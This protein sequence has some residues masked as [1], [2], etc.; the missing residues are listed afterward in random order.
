MS[1]RR[2]AAAPPRIPGFEHVAL[3]GSGGFSDVFLYEQQRPRRR[4]AVKVLL[5]EWAD[6]AQRAAFDAEADLMARLSTHPSIV[7]IYEADV[8]DD[9]RPYLA[10]EYCSRP[11]LGTRYRTE[12][13]PVAECLR[14]V[15]QV[16]GAVET[17][18][19]AGI[20]HRD[21]KPANILGTDYGHPVLTDF[22]ISSTLDGEASPEG[23]SIP[24]SP[25][26][27]F[28]D[29]PTAGVATDVWA[30]GATLWT[31]LAGRSPFEVPGGA[32]GS[33][34]LVHRICSQP[35][36]TT[37]RSDVP[38]SLEG[39][40]GAAMAKDPAARYATVLDLARALQRVQTELS[41]PVTPIDLLDDAVLAPE[42]RAGSGGPGGS[43]PGPGG[44]QGHG[45]GQGQDDDEDGTRLRGVVS[46]DPAGPARPAAPTRPAPVPASGP[47]F[48]SVGA[49]SL[50][51]VP[52][53]PSTPVDDTVLRGSLFA[54]GET[55]PAAG[56]PSS[57]TTVPDG[58]GTGGRT[59]GAP[60][61][62]PARVA[63]HAPRR[64]RARVLGGVAAGLAVLVGVVVGA[65]ALGGGGGGAPGGD[66]DPRTQ[67]DT[68]GDAPRADNLGALVPAV[69]DLKGTVHGDEAVFTWSFDRRQDGDEFGYRVLDPLDDSTYDMTSAP[70]ATV[71]LQGDE[72]CVEVVVAR[73][74][75]VSASPQRACASPKGGGS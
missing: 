14:V 24:W 10:M 32:N 46:I 13:L 8:A 58:A 27:S 69:T 11:S 7:T 44:G 1:R 73:E 17:A 4:V 3:V 20:L 15:V 47:S 51:Q 39:V 9:G 40:L 59:G 5:H 72:V 18:H 28:G 70:R 71:P 49:P 19:R 6:P 25:P 35:V 62:A 2:S 33:A 52:A 56:R 48:A 31:F 16:A 22:G 61:T 34:E 53:G 50:V 23:L 37:G 55:D 12:R 38:A 65:Q 41:L 60:A 45:R 26:E 74:G 29:P 63:P 67:A 42:A 66:R 30:L 21:I 68:S 36:P 57:A 43:G 75:K 54:G 64:H